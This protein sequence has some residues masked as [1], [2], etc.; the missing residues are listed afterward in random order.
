MLH[1]GSQLVLTVHGHIAKTLD[2]SLAYN[3]TLKHVHTNHNLK[4]K[5]STRS[6]IGQNTWWL[7]SNPGKDLKSQL[8]KRDNPLTKVI[9]VTLLPVDASHPF[10]PVERNSYTILFLLMSSIIS[11][12]LVL[13]NQSVYIHTW[14][15]FETCRY[16]YLWFCYKCNKPGLVGK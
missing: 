2:H 15:C 8:L 7:R 5:W 9:I 14:F 11:L 10:Q 13:H 6:W 4:V 12:S 3:Y 1:G 16:M